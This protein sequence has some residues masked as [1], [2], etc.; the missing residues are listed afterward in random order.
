MTEAACRYTGSVEEALG[1]PYGGTFECVRCGKA[2]PTRTKSGKSRYRR[3]GVCYDCAA[4]RNKR[5]GDMTPETE[6]I[7]AYVIW[8]NDAVAHLAERERVDWYR[9]RTAY[10][11]SDIGGTLVEMEALRQA[12]RVAIKVVFDAPAGYGKP[13]PEKLRAAC[14]TRGHS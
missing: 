9:L 10:A 2:G 7:T 5:R 12:D 3:D 13:T 14:E 1:I 11:V 6:R 4:T 8:K